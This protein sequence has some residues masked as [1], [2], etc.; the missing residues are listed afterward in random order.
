[1]ENKD[2]KQEESLWGE[3]IL[4][5]SYE[6]FGEEITQKINNYK[7]TTGEKLES[8]DSILITLN[9][10]EYQLFAISDIAS[11]HLHS[12]K[13]FM[14]M[15]EYGEKVRASN[16][17]RQLFWAVMKLKHRELW[18]KDLVAKAKIKDIVLVESPPQSQ[19]D[20]PL[21]RLFGTFQP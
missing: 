16:S 17:L 3:L 12:H 5:L 9:P 1:M 18:G 21:R 11:Q 4:F 6:V 20:N 13:A 8:S 2:Q 14:M 19:E 15:E 7:F 10:W